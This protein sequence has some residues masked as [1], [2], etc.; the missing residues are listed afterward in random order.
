MITKILKVTG[1]VFG[2]LIGI[3]VLYLLIVIFAP[4]FNVTK[5]PL[6][7]SESATKAQNDKPPESRKDVSFK[8]EGLS[9]SG[10]LYLPKDLSK[11]VPCIVMSHGFGATKDIVLESYALRFQESGLA[12]LTY[13]YR[14]FGES[15]GDPRQLFAIPYQLED[16]KAAIE[17][18]R[19]RKEI[20]SD[21]IALWGTS[22]GGGYGLVIAAQD[23]KIACIVGQCPALDGHA[24][25]KLALE[26]EGIGFFLRLFMHAQRDK[27]RSWFGLSDHKIPI[28]GKP[29][30]FAIVTAPG[31][32]YGYSKLVSPSFK[33]EVCARALLM[34]H[35]HFPIEYA[36]SVRCPVLLQICE[37]DN[38]V[39]MNSTLETAKRLGEY[40][41]VKRYPI[42][43]FDIYSGDH[44]EKSVSDQIEFFKKH[45]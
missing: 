8:V 11:P 22:A 39:S 6:P 29:G 44:F 35:G 25:F 9:V 21:R 16:L 43:H 30:T 32:F 27:G 24:D 26:R 36:K 10:W 4:G 37:K 41:E 38:L 13:D 34:S 18:A 1:N 40:A 3:I 17:Y 12:V 15:E 45:L 23:K 42:G 28:V 7:I 20:D 31:A 19:S 33:N 14:Y 2:I 5:Q